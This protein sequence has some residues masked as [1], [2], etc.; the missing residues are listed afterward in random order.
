[1]EVEVA[2]ASSDV[3]VVVEHIDAQ[4]VALGRRRSPQLARAETHAVAMLGLV[5]QAVRMR[6]GKGVEIFNV[7]RI[8]ELSDGTISRTR[9]Q[10]STNGVFLRG[11]FDF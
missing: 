1:M 8:G 2:P 7:G 11:Q 9:G 10:L 6:V 5:T 4:G 3:H